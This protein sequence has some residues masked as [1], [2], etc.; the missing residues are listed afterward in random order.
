MTFAV[1]NL[2]YGP[3]P[4]NRAVH[5]MNFRTRLSWATAVCRRATGRRAR[6]FYFALLLLLVALSG[7]IR[8]RSICGQP[9]NERTRH[10]DGARRNP[11]AYRAVGICGG[12]SAHRFWARGR[13]RPCLGSRGVS[14]TF[15]APDARS[16][17]FQGSAHLCDCYSSA[18]LD[19]N[20]RDAEALTAGRSPR[21]RPGSPQRLAPT[22]SPRA[23]SAREGAS[24]SS[25]P[26]QPRWPDR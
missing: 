6:R 13:C 10:Q 14:G 23:T 19:F 2:K 1:S 8:V 22:G 7:V 16:H 11:I 4:E 25:S 3:S 9:A 21:S 18:Q 24:A 15:Y 12:L 20:S 5:R 26:E 17:P